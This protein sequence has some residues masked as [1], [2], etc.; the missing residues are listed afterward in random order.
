MGN[1]VARH[2]HTQSRWYFVVD[3]MEMGT[4]KL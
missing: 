2:E 1:R 3:E 4:S